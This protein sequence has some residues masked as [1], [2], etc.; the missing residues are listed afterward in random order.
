MANTELLEL[1]D[2][3]EAADTLSP[4]LAKAALHGLRTSFPDQATA[5]LLP[6][7]VVTSTDAM[8]ALV[9]AAMP[10]WYFSIHGRAR[11]GAES[12]RCSLR[13]SDVLD[14]DEVLGTGEAPGLSQ[15]VAA[16]VLRV[17]ALR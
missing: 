5:G 9:V 14:D 7:S 1:A 11:P 13:R 16:A 10:G 12:W 3:I 6:D 4:Y 2:M 8:V 15:A 17:A